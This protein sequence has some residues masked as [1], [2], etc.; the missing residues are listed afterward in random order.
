MKRT[1]ALLLALAMLIVMLPA[2]S[3]SALPE[4]DT[5]SVQNGLVAKVWQLKA[6]DDQQ[7]FNHNLYYDIIGSTTGRGSYCG[8]DD[9]QRFSSSIAQLLETSK[10]VEETDN[11]TAIS[12][13]YPKDGYMVKWTGT[14]KATTAG[15]YYLVGR[16]I[17]NGFAMRVDQNGN[18]TF[19]DNE[20]FYDYWAANH[21][22]D[23]ADDKLVTNKGGFTLAANTETAVEIWFLEMDGGEALEIN[24]STSADGTGDKSF[25]DAGLTFSLKQTVYTSKLLHNHDKIYEVLP[26]GVRGG[27]CPPDCN[28]NHDTD[29]N[30]SSA[31][32]EG[33]HL[34]DTTI[35]ALKGKMMYVGSTIV[36][37]YESD[38]FSKVGS[39]GFTYE[40]C[41]V[42]YSGYV[43]ATVGGEFQFGTRNVDNCLMVEIKIGDTWTR[44]YEFWAAKVWNDTAETYSNTKVTLEKDKSYEIRAA[45]LEIDGGQV[46]ESKIKVNGETKSLAA[47]GLVFTTGK[48]TTIKVPTIEIFDG[49]KEWYYTTSGTLNATQIRDTKW[50][51]DATVYGA[52][53]KT[54]MPITKEIWGTDDTPDNN[55][56]L[57]AVTTFDIE[58]LSDIEGYELM[59]KIEWDDNIRM[60][61][62]GKLVNVELGWSSGT[63]TWSLVEEASDLL[64]A[65]K[66]TIAMKLVQ[67][68][69]GSSVNLKSLY[70]SLD[71]NANDP[72]EFKYIDKDGNKQSGRITTADQFLAYVADA[73]ARGAG[74]NRNDRI[75]IEA[76]LDFAGKTWV[77]IDKYVGKIYGNG[78]TFKNIT[79]TAAAD[80]TEGLV[81]V[82][83]LFN[84]FAND[85]GS[86]GTLYDLNFDSCSLT[87]N[88]TN[89]ADKDHAVVAGLVAGLVDRACIENVTVSNSELKGNAAYAA[90]IAG[91]A[92]WNYNEKGVYVENCGLIASTV[93][94]GVK[95]SA[96]LSFARWGDRVVLGNTYVKDITLV[97]PSTAIGCGEQWGNDNLRHVSITAE[98]ENKVQ[99]TLTLGEEDYKIYI[100]KREAGAGYYDVRIVVV[101]KKSWITAQSS[102]TADI[103]FI[104]GSNEEKFTE[105]TVSTAYTSI[106]AEADG[107]TEV[108]AG[109]ED[110]A[111]F[112]WVVTEVPADFL[113]TNPSVELS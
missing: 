35:D 31:T 75:S 33:N 80:A 67:G 58:S 73:N 105:Q 76:D 18:G 36:P 20:L 19:E 56:S 112:G 47:S 42:E 68:W 46:I 55:Q 69:G 45:Y 26:T 99:Q 109:A 93:T 8:F 34:Y 107:I 43:T 41:L 40:D 111:L 72:Y 101:A 22:F 83:L 52:W 21:W 95:A 13:V 77:P 64:V 63:P 17:D 100:Q 96:I 79:Y 51:T 15:T 10:I 48:P 37:N 14:V 4:A 103:A 7:P 24:V 102:I 60:Y 108:Y 32:A 106:K 53:S 85:S 23:G 38:A 12:P 70:L 57:W 16:K 50:T 89:G 39:L 65:G 9:V 1:L 5:A 30:C 81:T 110:T 59:A 49:T 66:N 90:G 6:A 98:G 3:L 82:G 74:S 91:I 44:V 71:E 27:A 2:F 104:N 92:S 84:V 88:A 54:A 97:A 62:N 78:H 25:A 29:G 113:E 61:I 94:A 11:V 86:T 28:R 87:V